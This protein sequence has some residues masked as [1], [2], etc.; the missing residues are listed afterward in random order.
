M[1][2]L[3]KKTKK[4][5]K[6]NSSSW[7]KEATFRIENH[8]WL[9]DSSNIARRILAAIEDKEGMNQKTLAKDVG[10]TFQYISKVVQGQQNLSLKTI[11]KIANVLGV[12]LITFPEYKYSKPA[13]KKASTLVPFDEIPALPVNFSNGKVI[14]MNPDYYLPTSKEPFSLAVNC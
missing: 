2:T 8:S 10:V 13:V 14:E 12:E 5:S 11:R 9:R 6:S 4:S 3:H 7:S 1:S